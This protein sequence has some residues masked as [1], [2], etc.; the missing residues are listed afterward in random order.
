MEISIL[1]GGGCFERLPSV[2]QIP[3]N[4]RTIQGWSWGWGWGRGEL[5]VGVGFFEQAQVAMSGCELT[6][7][8]GQG[9]G[10]RQSACAGLPWGRTDPRRAHR[11]PWD[12]AG[13]AF[14]SGAAGGDATGRISRL[15]K[16]KGDSLLFSGS[17]VQP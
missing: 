11:E 4:T 13:S 12:P 1:A 2:N 9:L 16:E 15:L 17:R 10:G 14:S 7:A 6:R 3:Q 5:C 8:G